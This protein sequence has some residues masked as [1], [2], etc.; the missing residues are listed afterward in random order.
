M[1]TNYQIAQRKAIAL[2]G[3]LEAAEALIRQAMKER[4]SHWE[5]SKRHCGSTL[6]TSIDTCPNCA[7]FRAWL[8]NKEDGNGQ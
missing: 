7:P 4:H 6:G 5:A 1:T 2:Q 3:R 8:G